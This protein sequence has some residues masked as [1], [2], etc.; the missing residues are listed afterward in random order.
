MEILIKDRWDYKQTRDS[1][2]EVFRQQQNFLQGD[3]VFNFL[4]YYLEEK[5]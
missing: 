4:P 3:V 2:L 1:S 5:I